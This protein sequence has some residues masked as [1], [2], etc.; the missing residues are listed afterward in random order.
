MSSPKFT[1]TLKHGD[2]WR[3]LKDKAWLVHD[4]AKSVPT[5]QHKNSILQMTEAAI[6]ELKKRM[7]ESDGKVDENGLVLYAEKAGAYFVVYEHKP[8]KA[9]STTMCVLGVV[10]AD[11]ITYTNSDA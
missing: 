11:E 7:K 8:E 10:F 4:N 5:L 2:D 1:M 3:F 9:V 6:E